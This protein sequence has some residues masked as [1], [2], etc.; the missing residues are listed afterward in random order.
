[1]RPLLSAFLEDRRY[2]AVLPHLGADIL[3]LGC[4]IARIVAWLRPDQRYAGVET[5]LRILD[6]LKQNRPDYKFYQ[7]DLDRDELGLT[8]QFDTILLLAVLEHLACPEKLLG[9]L[10]KYLHPNGKLLITTPSPSGEMVHRI[11]S[12]LGVFS[13]EAAHEHEFIFTR[14]LLQAQLE[15]NGLKVIRYS[16]FLL[17]GNQLFVCQLL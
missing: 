4:G 7:R 1:M 5:Q 10:P 8:G 16:T 15:R 12:R 17:G 14:H 3:D 6:W 2:Q 13:M 11:G 9:Q